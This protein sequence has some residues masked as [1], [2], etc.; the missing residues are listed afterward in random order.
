MVPVSQHY[1]LPPLTSTTGQVVLMIALSLPVLL[2]I[3]HQRD[4]VVQDAVVDK[5]I[6]Q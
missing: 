2:I 5:A 3:V 6:G 1:P 4:L